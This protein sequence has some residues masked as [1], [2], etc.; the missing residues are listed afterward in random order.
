MTKEQLFG[1]MYQAIIEGEK[2]RAADLA[3]GAIEM[4]ISPLKAIDQGFM[5]GIK[6]AGERFDR[7]EIYLPELVMAADAMTAAMAVLG[8]P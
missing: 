1:Q 5:K 8:G 3:K 6:E 4:G 7:E 2:A